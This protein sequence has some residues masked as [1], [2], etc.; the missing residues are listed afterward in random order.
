MFRHTPTAWTTRNR[1]IQNLFRLGPRLDVEDDRSVARRIETQ[2]STDSQ[3]IGRDRQIF[4]GAAQAGE[5]MM[6]IGVDRRR[7]PAEVGQNLGL[8]V[9]DAEQPGLRVV[10]V[11]GQR[12]ITD[13]SYMSGVGD[14]SLRMAATAA[15]RSAIDPIPRIP[16]QVA[17]PETRS[18]VLAPMRRRLRL[19]MG[20]T[21]E[22]EGGCRR[23]NSPERR[24][25][26]R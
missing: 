17:P 20:Y 25:G 13:Q 4:G 16:T 2:S 9:C 22:G 11:G 5:K 14:K 18:A 1:T 7:S 15:A 26:D 23:R 21:L 3:C 8:L 19:V 24:N 10:A 12:R 6:I